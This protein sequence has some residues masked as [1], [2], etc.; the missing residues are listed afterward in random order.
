MTE[1][2]IEIL[3]VFKDGTDLFAATF[4]IEEFDVVLLLPRHSDCGK[5][6][7]LRFALFS[8]PVAQ[9]R[10]TDPARAPQTRPFSSR[11]R[12]NA[13]KRSISATAASTSER[14]PNANMVLRSS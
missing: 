12:G 11:C 4:R 1:A 6:V 5:C 3:E 9:N 8:V 10:R 7:W 14:P 13:R 2:G